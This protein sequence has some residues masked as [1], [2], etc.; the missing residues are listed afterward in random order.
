MWV[1]ARVLSLDLLCSLIFINDFSGVI[2]PQ[3][4]IYADDLYIPVLTSDKFDKI[5]LTADLKND[6]QSVV[7]QGKKF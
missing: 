7:N 5:K 6:F 2:S 3:L 4:S 1:S